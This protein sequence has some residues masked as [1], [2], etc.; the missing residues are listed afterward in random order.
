MIGS[1]NLDLSLE[2]FKYNVFNE[3]NDMLSS[4][5]NFCSEFMIFPENVD[6]W[7]LKNIKIFNKEDLFERTSLD[8]F[9]A[10]KKLNNGS[11]MNMEYS[12]VLDEYASRFEDKLIDREKELGIEIKVPDFESKVSVLN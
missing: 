7:S 5:L 6:Y 2:Y 1:V 4:F 9:L 11:K 3:K 8:V 10:M 12:L